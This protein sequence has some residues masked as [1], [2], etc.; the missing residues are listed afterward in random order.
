MITSIPLITNIST[1]A[2]SVTAIVFIAMSTPNILDS[3]QELGELTDS[4]E[5]HRLF[6]HNS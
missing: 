2:I 4:S 6:Y 1:L 3:C 5:P